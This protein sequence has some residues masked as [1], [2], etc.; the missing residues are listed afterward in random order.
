MKELPPKRNNFKV[1][2]GYFADLPDR[3]WAFIQEQNKQETIT[4]P[5]RNKS[6]RGKI[7]SMIS[8]LAAAV[9]ALL[10]IFRT[11]DTSSLRLD[12]IS[13]D[14]IISYLEQNADNTEIIHL[15]NNGSLT[16]QGE[17]NTGF[18]IDS[19]DRETIELLNDADL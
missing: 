17:I 1:P 13:N 5:N 19:L 4:D 8:L 10:F 12:K 11:P 2:E 6:R 18:Q 16:I 3:T 15:V 7:I 9:I 14:E